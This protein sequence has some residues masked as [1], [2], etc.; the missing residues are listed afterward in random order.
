M[1]NYNDINQFK[2]LTE[3]LFSLFL[4][5]NGQPEENILTQCLE[6]FQQEVIT[7]LDKAASKKLKNLQ[8]IFASKD[9]KK[10]LLTNKFGGYVYNEENTLKLDEE[11]DNYCEN[12][13]LTSKIK[14]EIEKKEVLTLTEEDLPPVITHGTKK[15]LKKLTILR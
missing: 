13:D 8:V 12:V 11:W 4:S 7:V 10:N 2:K 6:E 9:S 3:N 5:E 1:I 14:E 15:L